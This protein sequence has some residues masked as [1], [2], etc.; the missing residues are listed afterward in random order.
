MLN[1]VEQGFSNAFDFCYCPIRTDLLCREMNRLLIT[2]APMIV[3]KDFKGHA[4]AKRMRMQSA[5]VS[6][7]F[8]EVVLKRSWLL[9]NVAWVLNMLSNFARL[10]S[11]TLDCSRVLW[12]ALDSVFK[13]SRLFLNIKMEHSWMKIWEHFNRVCCSRKVGYGLIW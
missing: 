3:N 12:T 8:V 1:V 6:S 10:L 11:T 5:C 2:V 13:P 9:W 7:T 4:Y